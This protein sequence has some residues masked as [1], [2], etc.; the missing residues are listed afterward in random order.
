MLQN[1]YT[2]GFYKAAAT[3]GLGKEAARK[4]VGPSGKVTPLAPRTAPTTPT[5]YTSE[6]PGGI[7][8][9]MPAVQHRRGGTLGPAAPMAAGPH[10]VEGYAAS[11]GVAASAEAAASHAVANPMAETQLPAKATTGFF[12]RQLGHAQDLG[13]SAANLAGTFGT[14]TNTTV[15]NRMARSG[16][17]T[18][19]G[20]SAKGLAPTLAAAGLGAYMLSGDSEEEKRR[21]AMMGM[22]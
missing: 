13:R 16:A 6:S 1:D 5:A 12:G 10:G 19:M 4:L 14:N 21:K 18:Q 15:A 22:R 7:P 8:S 3:Y 9:G 20:Q 2:A 11:P 17:L